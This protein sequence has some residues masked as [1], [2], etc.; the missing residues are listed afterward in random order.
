M[1]PIGHRESI[2]LLQSSAASRSS[3]RAPVRHGVS[4]WFL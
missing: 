1:A 3:Y 4:I 2:W